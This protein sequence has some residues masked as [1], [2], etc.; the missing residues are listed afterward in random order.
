[1]EAKKRNYRYEAG[2]SYVEGNTVRKLEA[3]PRY[4]EEREAPERKRQVQ[5]QTRGL[6]GINF[7]SLVILTVAIVAT[8]YVCV[9]YLML[10]NEVGLMQK[11]IV[12]LERNIYYL[13]R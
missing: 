9:E 6:S 13:V 2:T 3:V 11:N 10:Q 1:M 7:T 5:R 12:A 8:V 4:R